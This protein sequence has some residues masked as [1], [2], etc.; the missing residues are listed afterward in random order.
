MQTLDGRIAIWI[1]NKLFELIFF[2]NFQFLSKTNKQ[3]DKPNI[4]SFKRKVVWPGSLV[5]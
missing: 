4:L 2:F 1:K 3:K 5:D